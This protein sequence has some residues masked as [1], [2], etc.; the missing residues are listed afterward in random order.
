MGRRGRTN[1]GVVPRAR[2][3]SVDV[4]SSAHNELA[5]NGRPSIHDRLTRLGL[6]LAKRGWRRYR[7]GHARFYE[8][9][10]TEKHVHQELYDLRHRLRRE[11]VVAALQDVLCRPEPALILDVGC[12]VGGTA[13]AVARQSRV[14][15]LVYSE[16]DLRLANSMQTTTVRFVRGRAE[17]LPLTNESVDVAICL[18]VLEHLP[19]DR[20]AL[21]EL[22]RVL[23]AGGRL[24]VSV[25]SNFY[26]R[27]YRELI[28]H[29]RHYDRE[30][31]SEL[32]AATGFRIL[33][34]IDN[35]PRL[36]MLHYYPYIILE[37]VHQL[38]NRYGARKPSMYQRP[39]TRLPYQCV[40]GMLTR[41]TAK[42]SQAVLASDVRSTFVLAESVL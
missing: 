12:G 16:A 3:S 23:R 4:A 32:L 30:Q 25:P 18:E 9:F 19:D 1:G 5:M 41:M 13:L 6:T 7:S 38:L 28:G 15:G 11:A 22:H 10:F 26:F 33:S 24:I 17:E 21:T 31:L 29:H 37:A 8:E 40:C 35:Q 36:Q 2:V 27:E 14:I 20:A 34:Y 42:R 39:L